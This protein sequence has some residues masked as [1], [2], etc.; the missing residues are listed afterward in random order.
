[1]MLNGIGS[2]SLNLSF[3]LYLILYIPQIV[4]NQ[5]SAHLAEL[6]FLLHLILFSSILLDLFYGFGVNLPWQ[7]KTVSVVSFLVLT[8]QHYQFMQFFKQ[9]KS[10]WHYRFGQ[11]FIQ[12]CLLG[13]ILFFGFFL[14]K[15]SLI[16]LQLSNFLGTMA[17]ISGLI[18]CYPQITKNKKAQSARGVNVRFMYL[19]LGLSFLD[20]VSAWTLDWGWPNKL[21]APLN[22]LMMLILLGQQRKYHNLMKK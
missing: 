18:Y 17:R 6:S 5:K 9:V 15:K 21:G 16:S 8:I 3:Y 22:F 20:T 14:T 13:L 2:I 19:N 12:A 1:M 10:R 11:F 4:H 7:Y